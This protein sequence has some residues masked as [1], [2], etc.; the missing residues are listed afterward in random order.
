MKIQFSMLLVLLL[1]LSFSTNSF[2]GPSFTGVKTCGACHKGAKG[3][4]IFE[5][6]QS[7]DHAKAF[8]TLKSQKS[9]DIA[10]KMKISDPTTSDKCLNCHVTNTAKKDEGVSC[11]S[12]HGAGSDYKAMNVMKDHN[13]AKQKGLILGKGDASLCKKCHNP[14]SPTYKPFDYNKKWN[15]VKHS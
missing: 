15:M 13:L 10:A 1:M 7:T 3:K 9:K 6:W 11:E 2:A 12:C 4:N 14:N 5:K 8:E